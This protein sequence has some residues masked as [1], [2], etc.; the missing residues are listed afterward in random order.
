MVN[1]D[2]QNEKL[3]DHFRIDPEENFVLSDYATTWA[4]TEEIRQLNEK[5]LKKELKKY[6][7]SNLKQLTQAQELLWAS[8]RRSLLI[9]FQAMDAAGKDSTIKHVMTGVNPQ[10]VDV[11]SFKAPSSEELDHNFLWRY[12]QRVPQRGRI[13][14]FNRSYYEEVLIVKVHPEILESRPIPYGLRGDSFWSARYEDINAMEEHLCRSGTVVL[15]FFLNVSKEEQKQR[16]LERLKNPEKH[17]KFSE[18]DIEE[19]KYWNGYMEAFE[20]CIR[21]T[22]TPW[23]PWFVIPADDK[24]KMR[25]LVSM[26]ITEKIQSLDLKYP[27]VSEEKHRNLMKIKEK[28]ERE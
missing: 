10:G 13:G 11:H 8:N 20:D 22:S 18:S 1:G 27:E 19:R 12:W 28:L 5:G 6:I 23:A 9:I 14:I 4:G 21:A 17:W 24:W 25:A 2:T 7:K 16:F 15:K 3:M 26:I